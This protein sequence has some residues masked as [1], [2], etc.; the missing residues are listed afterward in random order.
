[1]LA[2]LLAPS[3]I[4]LGATVS[5]KKKAL[6]TISQI[7][8]DVRQREALDGRTYVTL[9]RRQAH[10]QM[11]EQTDARETSAESVLNSKSSPRSP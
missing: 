2:Q 11:A 9:P 8:A 7:F 1:M 5:S 4:Q 10:T 6:Q 3:R